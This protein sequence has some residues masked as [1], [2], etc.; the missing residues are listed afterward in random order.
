MSWSDFSKFSWYII[1]QSSILEKYSFLQFQIQISSSPIKNGKDMFLCL[2]AAWS[3][4]KCGIWTNYLKKSLSLLFYYSFW[5]RMD[6]FMILWILRWKII[7]SIF[8]PLSIWHFCKELR[9]I[10]WCEKLHKLEALKVADDPNIFYI[11]CFI[12]VSMRR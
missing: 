3:K 7:I 12:K 4:V 6:V 11:L 5:E 10:C 1:S 2:S 8:L 9:I